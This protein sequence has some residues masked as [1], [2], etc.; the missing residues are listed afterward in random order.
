MQTGIYS[1][2]FHSMK[3]ERSQSNNLSCPLKKWGKEQQSK[4]KGYNKYQTKNQ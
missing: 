4:E 1:F 2:K 3:E